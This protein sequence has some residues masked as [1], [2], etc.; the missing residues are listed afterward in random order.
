M[1]EQRR[2]EPS[3]IL[4]GHV[5][6]KSSGIMFHLMCT[7]IDATA[8][9]QLSD[10]AKRE[11][12]LRRAL[13]RTVVSSRDSEPSKVPPSPENGDT[14]QDGM[15]RRALKQS[16]L[17]VRERSALQ[18]QLHQSRSP[19]HISGPSK[20]EIMQ[21]MGLGVSVRLHSMFSIV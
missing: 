14:T 12:M 11:A 16:L 6:C 20:A 19:P 4:R 5:L 8:C 21:S 13:Q 2:R 7:T 15:I 9:W 3:Y 10:Q 18:R 1:P 17:S